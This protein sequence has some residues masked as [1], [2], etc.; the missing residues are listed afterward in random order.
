MTV[1]IRRRLQAAG[2]NG[3]DK[4]VSKI[5]EFKIAEPTPVSKMA[6]TQ[7]STT[8]RQPEPA[9]TL[10]PGPSMPTTTGETTDHPPMEEWK[11]VTPKKKLP[12]MSTTPPSTT[13][14]VSEEIPVQQPTSLTS[15]EE[16]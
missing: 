10:P 3:G 7:M 5:A 16:T 2:V 1:Q 11:V 14:A 13:E 6:D 4:T 12:R 9:M 15:K 8:T